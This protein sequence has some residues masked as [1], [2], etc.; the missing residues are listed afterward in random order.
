MSIDRATP[1]ETQKRFTRRAVF[2]FGVQAAFVGMLGWR[3]RQLQVVEAETY[4]TLAEE[5]RI[6]IRLIPPARGIIYDRDGQPIAVNRQNYRI[7][8]I[9]EQAGD[10]E[11]VLDRVAQLVDLGPDRRERVLRD[12]RSRSAFVPVTVLEHMAWED[13]ARISANAPALP[14]ILP[15]VG[16]SRFYPHG[17]TFAHLVGYVGPV[18]D[19]DLAQIDDPDP[20]LQIPDFQIGK[21]GIEDRHEDQ[22]RGQAGT[23]RIEV[24]AAGRVIREIDRVEG[25]PGADLQLT[26]DLDLQTY[27][28]E[29]M[30]GESAACVVMDTRTGDV[31][32]LA[33]SPSFDPNAFVFGISSADWRALNEDEYRPMYSKPISG[34]YPPGST[35]KM[36]VA[37]A[38]LED[39]LT[40]PSEEIFCGGSI[41]FGDR[42]FHCWRRGGH[43]RMN[44]TES[45]EE[46]CDIY[47]YE[48]AQRLGI[49]RITEMANLFGLGVRPDLPLPAIASGL[50]PTRAW[51]QAVRG[52]TWQIGDTLNASIGQG[53]QL[54]SPMQLAIMTARLASGRA[55]EPRLLRT[56]AAQPAEPGDAAALPVSPGNLDIIR[57][58]MHDVMN[59]RRGTAYRSRIADPE[60]LFAGK[61]GTSQVRRITEAERRAGVIRNEDLPWNRRDHALF[62]G[63]APYHDPR[64]AVSVVVEHGGGGSAAA[65]PIARD[66]MMRALYRG[67]PP[68]EAYP[69]EIRPQI[70]EQRRNAPAGAAATPV[71]SRA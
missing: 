52:E 5:N 46:S 21:T 6:N 70:E 9:R 13:F 4:R 31:L 30:N 24:N 12:V 40:D 14:G 16:L 49:D 27:A 64:Y 28:L 62:V 67:E 54:A 69:P 22:L 44:V 35:F 48:M 3:M 50:T 25:T 32:A 15:E 56:I 26:V 34:A 29:R 55:I 41:F 10:V 20:V 66:V 45:I 2:L 47:Y 58:S 33:S 36:L 71:R 57:R 37:L 1:K 39:G 59:N 11:A 51:K 61:T 8:I 63:Y 60:N 68:L 38:A 17:P 43:G 19:Y 42:R 23:S 65:A 53:Y 7:V 18:S